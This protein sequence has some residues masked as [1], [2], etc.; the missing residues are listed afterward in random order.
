MLVAL[1]GFMLTIFLEWGMGLDNIPGKK[2]QTVGKIGGDY[3]GIREF[4]QILE[5]RKQII[6]SQGGQQSQDDAALPMQVWD[7][8]V[9]EVITNKAVSDLKLE[10]TDEEVYM[11]LITYP[12][13]EIARSEYFQTNG[14][15]DMNKYLDFVK[16]PS[17][18]DSPQM[19]YIEQMLKTDRIPKH[20]LSELLASVNEPSY[21]Q[22]EYE[23][24]AQNERVSFE[25]IYMHPFA[26]S[27]SQEDL[28]EEKLLE[29]YNANKAN[30]KTDEK[31]LL[32]F[33]RFPKATTLRDEEQTAAA[34]TEIRD[35]IL[36]ENTTFAEEA[37]VESDDFG[38][39]KV[40]G[41]LGWF[42]KGRMVKEFEEVAFST[43][44]GEISDPFK[45]N[46]GYHIVAVD[47]VK[48]EDGE[49]VEVK[50]QHIL[51][52]IVPSAETLDSIESLAEN[53]RESAEGNSL[54]DIAK[55]FNVSVDSTAPF[56]RGENPQ[57]IGYV[58]DLGNFVFDSETKVGDVGKLFE[59]EDAL[60]VVQL[61]EKI[62]KGTLPFEHAKTKIKD[63]ISDSLRV[64]G[65]KDYLNEIKDKIGDISFEEFVETDDKL[66]A[67]IAEDVTRKQYI[68]NIGVNGEA[69]AAAF[70]A[71]QSAISN[72]IIG[73]NGAY[74]VR[75]KSKQLVREMPEGAPEFSS[76]RDQ[77]KRESMDNI[78]TD[79]FNSN[80]KRLKITEN[81][82]EF[83]Y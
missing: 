70:A 53:I 46:Y 40:G 78:Y 19:Q 18:Y 56:G 79:W 29:H 77:I 74:L 2:G 30:F 11:Y 72:P 76:I 12:L 8:Y 49:V 31:A 62:A 64:R 65:A 17:S 58:A 55:T 26:I 38:S 45:S 21:S 82:R 57:K 80:K 13:P 15:F 32:Y 63:K 50:A 54:F 37:T 69:V 9:S 71:P 23:Y 36:S 66:T 75:T 42:G 47:S 28:S 48:I 35:N 10:A 68:P 7:D 14:Q 20:K 24:K 67:G 41:E 52:H 6:R 39:A 22:I 33:V 25:Y 60:F 61:K 4:S 5:R 59:T 1:V 81:V 44:A 27:V 34:L 83:Y 51:K 43:P 3:V 73:D 16:T